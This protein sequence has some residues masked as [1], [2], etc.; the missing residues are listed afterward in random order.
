MHK[1]LHSEWEWAFEKEIANEPNLFCVA[2]RKE[3]GENYISGPDQLA[4]INTL[5]DQGYLYYIVWREK[6]E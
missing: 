5:P 6:G 2:E 3:G 1:N 4:Y